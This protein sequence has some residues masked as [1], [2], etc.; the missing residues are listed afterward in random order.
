[1]PREYFEREESIPEVVIEAEL[2]LLQ[3]W[4]VARKRTLF[5]HSYITLHQI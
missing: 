2:V 5:D 4:Y 3:E 1:M